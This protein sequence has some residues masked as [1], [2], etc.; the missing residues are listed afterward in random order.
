MGLCQSS[1]YSVI[2]TPYQEVYP[3]LEILEFFGNPTYALQFDLLIQGYQALQERSYEDMRS[4]YQIS[5]IHGLPYTAY[6]GV[7]GE[8]PYMSSEF[9]LGRWGGYCHHRDILFPTWHRGYILLIENQLINEAKEIANKYPAQ[10][11]KKYVKA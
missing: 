11:K 1:R 9:K 6:D 4:F 8:R 5:G 2:V 7:T 3:R 10:Q